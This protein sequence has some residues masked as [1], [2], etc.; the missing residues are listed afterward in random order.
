MV[1]LIPSKPF[2]QVTVQEWLS[3][4]ESPIS[5]LSGRLQFELHVEV[6]SASWPHC[7]FTEVY[8]E[9]TIALDLLFLLQ[10]L[11]AISIHPEFFL[12]HGS[13]DSH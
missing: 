1:L 7:I 8:V 4:Y 12:K 9:G 3:L 6:A 13:S 11:S 10:E 5:R 2:L